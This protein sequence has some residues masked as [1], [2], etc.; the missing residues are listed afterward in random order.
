MIKNY[1]LYN[2]FIIELLY[3]NYIFLKINVIECECWE[4]DILEFELIFVI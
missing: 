3:L 4:Y 2:D 1:Y